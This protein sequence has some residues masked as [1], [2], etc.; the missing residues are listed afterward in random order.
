MSA[1]YWSREARR[2]RLGDEAYELGLAEAEAAP[3]PSPAQ[4]ALITRIFAPHV[5][6]LAAQK[7]PQ[8]TP[9]A[10]AA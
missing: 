2:A 5:K 7:K 6:R 3:D 10:R 4:V 9:A 1:G 8:P